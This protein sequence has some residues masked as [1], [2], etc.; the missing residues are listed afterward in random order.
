M[1][2]DDIGDNLTFHEFVKNKKLNHLIVSYK[3]KFIGIIMI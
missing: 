3:N 2:I 1:I